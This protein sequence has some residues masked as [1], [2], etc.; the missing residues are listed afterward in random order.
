[1]SVG[2]E[3]A[4]RR[5]SVQRCRVTR[6]EKGGVDVL[7]KAARIPAE[8]DLGLSEPGQTPGNNEKLQGLP[9][10]DAVKPEER[11]PVEVIEKYLE[12]ADELMVPKFRRP[13]VVRGPVI[14]YLLPLSLR[15]LGAAAEEVPLVV[16]TG[17]IEPVGKERELLALGGVVG[18][19][20]PNHGPELSDG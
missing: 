10:T 16:P 6:R 17:A 20:Q 11:L 14:L 5:Q 12:D 3:P 4:I 18:V 1:M 15:I 13:P 19:V 2:S 9:N 7:T 8:L